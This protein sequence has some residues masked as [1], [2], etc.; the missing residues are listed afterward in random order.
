MRIVLSLVTLCLGSLQIASCQSNAWETLVQEFQDDYERLDIS[1]LRIAYLDN[2]VGIRSRASILEQERLFTNLSQKLDA[3]DYSRLQAKQQLEYDLL[4]YQ[5]GLNTERIK[6]ELEWLD[7]KP[8]TISIDGLAHIPN[9]KRW[10]QYFLKRW[11]DDTVTPEAL[12]EFGMAEIHKVLSEMR[13]LQQKSGLD[14]LAFQEYIQSDVFFYHD[15]AIVQK[16]FEDYSAKI[17]KK[18]PAYFPGIPDIPPVQIERGMNERLA[19]VPAFYNGNTLYYNYFDRPFNK[20]QIIF[21]YLHEAL[22]GH[23]YEFNYRE[24]QPLLPLQRMINNPGYSEGW[25]AYVE[26]LGNDIDAYDNIYDELGKWEWDIIR[27]VRVSLD[28]GLNYYGWT[29]EKALAF[30]QQFIQGQDDIAERE[31]ARMRRWPCQVITYKYGSQKILKWKAQF[32]SQAGYD[33]KQFHT[34]FLKFGPLPFSILEK[35]LLK[36]LG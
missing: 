34:T 26:E 29:D 21:L 36:E 20:R 1:S 2:L 30:W 23:H 4:R 17:L 33:M 28:V 14:S 24:M 6:L 15:P 11:I 5:I 3:V 8:D 13:A 18:L 7:I 22:P 35:W 31:I 19:Q 32:E 10:Y 12:F 25:A 9:G 16:A 27:S